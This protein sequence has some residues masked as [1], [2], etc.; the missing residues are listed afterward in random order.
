MFCCSTIE[1]QTYKTIME[2]SYIIK[3][4]KNSACVA[5][6]TCLTEYCIPIRCYCLSII[7]DSIQSNTEFHY[8][9]DEN[10]VIIFLLLAIEI[11]PN[12]QKVLTYVSISVLG[13]STLH[14]ISYSNNQ[15]KYFP[16]FCLFNFICP[17]VM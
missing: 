4:S 1:I 17:S 7:F 9:V 3:N 6:V 15:T 16:I 10:G 8:I 12:F 2:W 5:A 13:F 14:D 11:L